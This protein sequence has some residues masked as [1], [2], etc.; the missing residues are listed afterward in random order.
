MG[1]KKQH[2]SKKEYIKDAVMVLIPLI[3]IVA[4][5]L[6]LGYSIGYG[7][8]LS[9]FSENLVSS[10]LSN[11]TNS[12]ECKNLSLEDSAYCLRDEVKEF[13][14]YNISKT[15]VNNMPVEELKAE[16]GV[17]QH[18][19]EYYTARGEE[20]GFYARNVIFKTDIIQSHQVSIISDST[21]YCLMD[22]TDVKCNKFAPED[23]SVGYIAVLNFTKS[24]WTTTQ[25]WTGNKS[26]F[27]DINWT[28]YLA[29]NT[30]FYSTPEY[31]PTLD[32]IKLTYKG[33]KVAWA[34]QIEKQ[35]DE[36]FSKTILCIKLE[37]GKR[38]CEE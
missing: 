10:E 29:I 1:A 22:Q 13:Y 34:Y 4:S 25:N 23:D 30:S 14:Y 33:K 24:N 28:G 31:S 17:C 27:L 38:Y 8:A 6:W 11:Y 15:G 36:Y 5:F 37:N 18:Y 3:M 26:L 12:S 35:V 20:L 7:H 21:G 2:I 32:I 19:A 9:E 16:G